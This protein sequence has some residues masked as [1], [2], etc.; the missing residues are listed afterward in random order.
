M[1][2]LYQ[3]S[4]IAL[5]IRNTDKKTHFLT[6]LPSYSI[7]M[8]LLSHLSPSVS[9]EKSLCSGLTLVDEMLI[10]LMKILRGSTNK[11][12]AFLFDVEGDKNFSSMDR[13]NVSVPST[14][15][16]VARQRDV[17][18]QYAQLF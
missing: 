6:G 11:L 8:V 13:Y 17:H 5:K 15:G 2:Q 7:F 18:C 3:A 12:I 1:K 9:K 14:F 10:V 16:R 4:S